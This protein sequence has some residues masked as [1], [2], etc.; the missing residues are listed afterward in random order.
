VNRFS[1]EGNSARQTAAADAEEAVMLITFLVAM[2]ALVIAV[3]VRALLDPDY[4]ADPAE[5]ENAVTADW[6]SS[7]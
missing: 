5:K 1:A 7:I 2:L 4:H 3:A 6:E